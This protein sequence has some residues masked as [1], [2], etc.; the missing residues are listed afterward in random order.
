MSNDYE[1]KAKSYDDD[2]DNEADIIWIESSHV[3]HLIQA[4]I[5]N[6]IALCIIYSVYLNS[7]LT[8]LYT[9]YCLT[10]FCAPSTPPFMRPCLWMIAPPTLNI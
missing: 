9:L 10:L 1:E 3:R 7:S 8:I 2:D 5:P 4:P 6:W